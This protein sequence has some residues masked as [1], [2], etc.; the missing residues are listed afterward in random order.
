MTH[1]MGVSMNLSG[2]THNTSLHS[3]R[4]RG[5]EE[6]A[7]EAYILV[8]RGA[9]DEVNKVICLKAKWY[10]TSLLTFVIAERGNG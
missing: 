6:E 9:D 7:T 5:D 2:G 1:I 8:R 3:N 10:N 4:E